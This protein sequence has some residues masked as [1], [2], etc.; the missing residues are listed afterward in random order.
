MPA[1]GSERLVAGSRAIALSIVRG[2]RTRGLAAVAIY[3][4]R[5]FNWFLLNSTGY[6]YC[7]VKNLNL[8]QDPRAGKDQGRTQQYCT[9]PGAPCAFV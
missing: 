4:G 9:V 2:V 1:A 7:T 3:H 5:K 8:G 6:G